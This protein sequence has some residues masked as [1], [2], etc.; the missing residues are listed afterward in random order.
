M[1]CSLP[2]SSA[3]GISQ[4]GI[5]EWFAIIFTRGSP[6]PKSPALAGRFFITEPPGQ[7]ET[8]IWS[9]NAISGYLSKRIHIRILKTFLTLTKALFT[10]AKVWK[11][12]K[13]LLSNEWIKMWYIGTVEYY[14]AL[15][16]EGNSA[17][18]DKMD[19]LWGHYA[20][21]QEDK[22]CMIPLTWGT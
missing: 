3:H 10:I 16:K 21:P 9:S 20:K 22:Y 7:P 5:L 18:C 11:P 4:A 13:C 14:S 17:I 2:G 12:P 15:K 1:D 19:E 6:W 8:T